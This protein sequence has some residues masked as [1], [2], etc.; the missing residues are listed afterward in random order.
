MG[1][2]EPELM[3]GLKKLLAYDEN[4]KDGG[5]ISDVFCLTFEV[6]W[7]EFDEVKRHELKPGGKDIEV[8]EANR[9][10]YVSLY[11]EWVLS[12]SIAKQFEDFKVRL[13]TH[14]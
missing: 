1:E 2:I 14:M 12:G 8:T 5:S 9:Q 7:I 6:D 4:S 10:E 3:G 13:G 11:V